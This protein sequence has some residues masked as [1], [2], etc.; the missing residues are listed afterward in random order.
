MLLCGITMRSAHEPH[1]ACPRPAGPAGAAQAATWALQAA[2]TRC[3]G[4]P[5][6]LLLVPYEDM[7]NHSSAAVAGFFTATNW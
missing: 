3:H 4:T 2:Y 7:A 5:G 1:P 6:H